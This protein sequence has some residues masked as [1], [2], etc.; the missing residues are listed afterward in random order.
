M[1]KIDLTAA[2][3]HCAG[4]KE[5]ISKSTMIGCFYC[6]SLFSGEAIIL[7]GSNTEL[8]PEC[9]IDALIGDASGYPIT[10]EFLQEM[11]NKYF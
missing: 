9:G 3:K 5:E 1:T 11:H 4:N 10:R 6:M 8:C 2:H 7:S